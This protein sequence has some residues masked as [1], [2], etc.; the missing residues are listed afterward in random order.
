MKRKIFISALAI[1][2][3]AVLSLGATVAYFQAKTE[4]TVN[5]FKFGNVDGEISEPTWIP[6]N[7]TNLAPGKTLPKDPKITLAADSLDAYV[8]IKVT[9][10]DAAILKTVTTGK[11]D[12][13]LI[14]K[15][16]GT[17]DSGWTLMNTPAIDT[18]KDEI[19]YIYG[20]NTILTKTAPGNVT[21]DLFTA[22]TVPGEI[23]EEN[24]TATGATLADG[25]T[26]TVKGYLIQSDNITAADGKTVLQTAYTN[27]DFS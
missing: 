20:Y 4:D 11:T 22:I 23:T 10:S 24:I 18:A 14:T 27:I 2:L 15:L 25:F 1:A 26:V 12:A 8:F 5:T 13:E 17:I 19:V 21:T 7:A 16:A 3:I 6:E 9:V